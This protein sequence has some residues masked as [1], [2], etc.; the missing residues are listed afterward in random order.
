[1]SFEHGLNGFEDD[2]DLRITM[3]SIT[4][5]FDVSHFLVPEHGLNGFEDDTDLRITMFSIPD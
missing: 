2:T 5:L 1:L 3:F 4:V